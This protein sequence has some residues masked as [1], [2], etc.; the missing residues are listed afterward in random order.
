[1]SYREWTIDGYGF[2]VDD[3]CPCNKGNLLELIKQNHKLSKCLE[4][5]YQE[6]LDEMLES[7]EDDGGFR[8]LAAI[9]HEIINENEDIGFS[10]AE[11]FDSAQYIILEPHYSWSTISE[12]ERNAT[13][14]EIDDIL[15]KYIRLL[16][17]KK[18]RIEYQEVGNG[19]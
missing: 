11:D 16:T 19:G 9:L 4:Y 15:N 3:I 14:G 10:L 13:K 8:G 7:Y 1:M 5:D 18:V 12:K 17:D 2:C 6:N